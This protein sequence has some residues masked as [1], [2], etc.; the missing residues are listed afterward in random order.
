MIEVLVIFGFDDERIELMAL[1]VSSFIFLGAGVTKVLR[2]STQLMAS[3][4]LD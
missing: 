4:S 1:S 2:F 3:C